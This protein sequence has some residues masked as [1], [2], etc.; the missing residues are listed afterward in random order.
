MVSLNYAILGK[1]VFYFVFKKSTGIYTDMEIYSL[2]TSKKSKL[3][4]SYGVKHG[5][6]VYVLDVSG[7][8]FTN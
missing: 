1:L 3:V 2:H 5:N 6:R 4:Y 7:K 8:M